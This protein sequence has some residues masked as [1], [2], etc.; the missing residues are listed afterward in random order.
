MFL[1]F[2][3]VLAHTNCLRYTKEVKNLSFREVKSLTK[4]TGTLK[5]YS[6]PDFVSL[7]PSFQICMLPPSDD[8]NQMFIFY[9]S[10]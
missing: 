9:Y 5:E 6:C 2:N 8:N 3:S 4:I 7:F 1:C 10:S